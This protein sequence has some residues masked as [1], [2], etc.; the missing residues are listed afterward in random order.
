MSV[1]RVINSQKQHNVNAFLCVHTSARHLM[2]TV[3]NE[4][5]TIA[6]EDTF[7]SIARREARRK[8]KERKKKLELAQKEQNGFKSE[9]VDEFSVKE[10]EM[11][12][13]ADEE[14]FGKSARQEAR[15]NKKISN[16]FEPIQKAEDEF[17]T[18]A[19]EEVNKFMEDPEGRGERG[20]EGDK[21][22]SDEID[23]HV[24]LSEYGRFNRGLYNA[25]YYGRKIEKL[26]KQGRV[27]DAIQVL[28]HEMLVEKRVL[29]NQ[30]VFTV[31]I[32]V[33]GRVGYTRKAFQLF[34]KMKKMGLDP[35]DPTY[36]ALFNACSNSP[37]KEDGLE[38]SYKLWE[39]MQEKA[40]APNAMMFKAMIKAFGKCGDL[41]MAFEMTDRMIEEGL[42]L[43]SEAYCQLLIAC[44]SDK[45]AG[46]K[47]AIEVWRRMR[48]RRVLPTVHSYHLLIRAIHDCGLGEPYIANQLLKG[49]SKSPEHLKK[50]SER[51]ADEPKA[52]PYPSYAEKMFEIRTQSR[53]Q[54]DEN[55]VAVDMSEE[56]LPVVNENKLTPAPW[57]KMNLAFDPSM[58]LT[59]MIHEAEPEH[60]KGISLLD[61]EV[62]NLLNPRARNLENVVSL[63]DTNLPS[64]RFALIGGL[65]GILSHMKRDKLKPDSTTFALIAHVLPQSIEAETDLFHAMGTYN[66]KP[67]LEI[68]NV[69]IRRQ[70]QRRDLQAA[71]KSV[72]HMSQQGIQPNIATFGN[73]AL[74]CYTQTDGQALLEDMM[75]LSVQPTLDIFGI[76]LRRTSNN[77][78]YTL[79][80][81]KTM[82]DSGLS[83][84]YRILYGLENNI[85]WAKRMIVDMEH[86]KE[87]PLRYARHPNF[88]KDFG[89]FM[90]FYSRW[91][92][93]SELTP[94]I[95][96][97]EQFGEKPREGWKR[98]S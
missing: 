34:N 15:R 32:G 61:M 96:P 66:I 51:L 84:D 91:L 57:W 79:Y 35:E 37:F 68:F 98:N 14:T 62:P 47:H 40:I 22:K 67:T 7:G 42:G 52:S 86:G 71:K 83:P 39:L 9:A 25:D 13:N 54:N 20:Y 87:L 58:S 24:R 10:K 77:F 44:I 3:E 1:N 75:E 97:W 12:P 16:Q 50:G 23:N 76:L 69:V 36:T 38:R 92:K 27:H 95:H 31:L 53:G 89:K 65:P 88:K 63:K 93:S 74:A 28:E 49:S 5:P 2:D 4:I 82:R 59:A 41:R 46:L 21:G 78:S 33:L 56:S 85:K 17:G 94:D 11:V 90:N 19:V 73:L 55:N 43:D 45:H 81:C 6:K 72:Q 18:L 80:L 8:K 70:A 48:K 29:P 60:R 30:Y 64:E 26:G